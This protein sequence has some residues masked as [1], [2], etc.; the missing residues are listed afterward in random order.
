MA[1]PRPA[2]QRV[3]QTVGQCT[4]KE[5]NRSAGPKGEHF[6][7]Q[8]RRPA[9]FHRQPKDSENRE[10]HGYELSKQIAEVIRQ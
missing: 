10:K 6:E 9:R 1:S 5:P 8:E 3:T 2:H 4:V 7:N